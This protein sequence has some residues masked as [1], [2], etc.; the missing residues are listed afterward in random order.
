MTLSPEPDPN[1]KESSFPPFFV[2]RGECLQLLKED[3]TRIRNFPLRLR[4]QQPHSEQT[5]QNKGGRLLL[6][7]LSRFS[8]VRLCVT[9]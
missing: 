8:R 7:L 6:L 9:P 2:M 4:N 1:A 3:G 5:N